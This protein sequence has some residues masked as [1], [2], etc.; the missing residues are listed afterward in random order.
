MVVKVLCLKPMTVLTDS[1]TATVSIKVDSVNDK[2]VVSGQSLSVNEDVTVSITLQGSD[3]DKDDLTFTVLSQPKNGALSGTGAN[4]IYTPKANYYGSDSFTFKAND[5]VADSNTATVTLG[6][7]K[8]KLSEGVYFVENFDGVKLGPFESDS[9]SNGDGTDWASEGPEGWVMR[10]N[11]GHGLT[12]G[13]SDVVEFDGWTFLDPVSWNATAEQN[14]SNFT[15]GTGVIAVADSDEYDD[16]DDA[17][18]N[19]SLTTPSIDI[20]DASGSKLILKYDSSWRKEPHIG[21]VSVSYDEGGQIELLKLDGNSPDAY[22]ETVELELNN[23]SGAKSAVI[24]WNYEGHNNWW[25]A[26]DNISVYE[27]VVKPALVLS[28]ETYEYGESI[29]ATFSDGP[30]DAK[31][32]IGIW[33]DEQNP[34]DENSLAWFYVDSTKIGLVG[35]ESGSLN[36]GKE[37]PAGKY[38]VAL[39]NNDKKEKILASALFSINAVTKNK[40]TI[41]FYMSTDNDLA[42]TRVH[43]SEVVNRLRTNKDVQL[44][45][46]LDLDTTDKRLMNKYGHDDEIVRDTKRLVAG[47]TVDGISP[48]WKETIVERLSENTVEENRM[49]DP[50]TLRNFLE[51]GIKNYPAER[52]A[53]LFSNHGGSWQGFGGDHQDGL[54][55]RWNLKA[56]GMREAITEAFANTG[57][58][59]FEW[60]SF[61]ACLMGATEVLDAFNGLTDIVIASPEISYAYNEY[62]RFKFIREIMENPEISNNELAKIEMDNWYGESWHEYKESPPFGEECCGSHAAYDMN[63][64]DEFIAS[65]IQFSK[66]LSIEAKNKNPIILG[67]RRES[68]HYWGHNDWPNLRAPTDTID[69]PH[70]AQLLSK[71]SVGNLKSSSDDLLEKINDLI[72]YKWVGTRRP[73]I[74]GLNIYYPMKGIPLKSAVMYDKTYFATGKLNQPY[75]IFPNF[76]DGI[77]DVWK[78]NDGTG[79]YWRT[80]LRDLRAFS[81]SSKSDINFILK[82]DGTLVPSRSGEFGSA[83]TGLLTATEKS[84]VPINFEI[85]NNENA[86]EYFI[87]LVSNTATDNSNQFIYFGELYRA[88]I[89]GKNQNNY[90]WNAKLPVISLAG[91]NSKAPP[92]GPIGVDRKELEGEIPLYLGGWWADHSLNK[93]ISHA[94]YQ[95]PGEEE[96]TQLILTTTFEKDGA[97]ELA[98]VMVHTSIDDALIGD[99][100]QASANGAAPVGHKFQFEPGGKLW[101]VYYMEEPDPENPNEWKPYF[102][103]FKDSYIKIPENG[104]DGLAINWVTVEPG[105]YRA[106]V[107]VGD[108]FG[109]LSGELKFDIIVEDTVKSL[110][111]LNVAEEGGRI[112]VNWPASDG[113]SQSLLQWTEN[114][115]SAWQNISPDQYEIENDSYIYKERPRQEKRFYRLIKP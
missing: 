87:N 25:W 111:N 5:G 86:Y 43:K 18:L 48:P 11:N 52:Y 45:T 10:K 4:L 26:I 35:K 102:V 51:W 61:M 56:R 99:E 67:A 12:G 78:S 89:D 97:G 39:V 3:E 42:A 70:F 8:A 23:P 82:N 6:I 60:V 92:V 88:K 55:K 84:P 53:L 85:N 98:S 7:I 80:F 14:R 106:E 21:S 44:V 95:A 66:T 75:D 68:S 38:K 24:S 71:N 40:W 115:R 114:L 34:I 69:L 30:G 59:K 100:H 57:E 19:A 31:N 46:Q 49:D 37:L 22:N 77:W 104:N 17:R 32:W 83:E 15:K 76:W 9:E 72:M 29:I 63:K 64:F 16:K 27:K 36:F 94:D 109:N 62:S 93:M 65:F 90:N 81:D 1:N 54:G 74:S 33:L 73:E 107:Q 13:G 105:N 112:V 47:L 2:P 101:P 79:S 91:D 58:K 110:P 108:Y 20:S 28:K 41:F 113:G 103:W 50:E 96:K